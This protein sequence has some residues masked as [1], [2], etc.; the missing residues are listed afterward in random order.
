M[1]KRRLAAFGYQSAEHKQP[2]ELRQTLL[3]TIAEREVG[4]CKFNPGPR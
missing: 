2:D 3:Q 1:A 4:L